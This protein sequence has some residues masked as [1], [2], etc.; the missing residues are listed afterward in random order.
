MSAPDRRNPLRALLGLV[1]LVAACDAGGSPDAPTAP[2][3]ALAARTSSGD[4]LLQ[5]MAEAPGGVRFQ[6]T[7]RYEA[8]WQVDGQDELLVYR[9]QAT[10]D[11]A[12]GYA[13][14]P[15]E[16]LEPQLGSGP[17]SLFLLLQRAREGFFFRHRD[18]AI[19]D[20]ELFLQRWQVIDRGP[21]QMLGRRCVRLEV[22]HQEDPDGAYHLVVDTESG[23][24]LRS[25]ERDASGA[26]VSLLEFETLDLAPDLSSTLLHV[27][28]TAETVVP[29]E[30]GLR[31]ALPF[32]PVRPKV[33]PEGF[34][35]LEM[36]TVEDL[37]EG[38]EWAR[39]TYGDG[40]EQLF[41]LHTAH[42]PAEELAPGGQAG[43]GPGPGGGTAGAGGR[44]EHTVRFAR[45]GPW[46]L[47]FGE[48]DG[49]SY[50]VLGKLDEDQLLLM[51]ESAFF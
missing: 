44:P 28:A 31:A 35:L 42:G 20:P 2:V 43:T 38:E 12:G 39:L 8:H 46:T 14:Q 21:A 32:V 47:L 19:R 22:Q 37:T 33:V 41:F 7:R 6:A 13:I 36:A 17:E 50:V 26:L 24:V 10:S 18:F 11:G 23:L 45:V 30:A 25:E 15:L 16:L 1:L 29:S 49:Q 27:P 9:E 3:Q 4:S 51:V 48:I 40:V 34:E 5:A